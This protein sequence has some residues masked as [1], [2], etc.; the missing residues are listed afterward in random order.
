MSFSYLK[1]RDDLRISTKKNNRD[2]NTNNS[3]S[4]GIA[5]RFAAV[6]SAKRDNRIQSNVKI[7]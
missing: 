6:K 2:L 5:T 3:N 4:N 1:D 7:Y